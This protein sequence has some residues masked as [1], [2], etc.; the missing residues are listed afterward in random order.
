MMIPEIYILY[1]LSALLVLAI[2]WLIRFEIK[3]RRLLGGKNQSLD[4]TISEIRKEL[5]AITKYR[6][7]SEKY[8]ESVERRIRK[9]VTGVETIRFNPFKGDGSGGDQSFSTAF[10][11][12]EGDGVVISSLYSRDRVSVFAKPIKK[13]SSEYEMTKEEKESLN[14]AKDSAQA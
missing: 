1:A 11:N 4:S 10:V 6:D 2:L 3:L 8:L 9:S 5:S 7:A 12:E 14:K 13:L